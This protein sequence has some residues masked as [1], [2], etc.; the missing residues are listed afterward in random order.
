MNWFIISGVSNLLLYGL[1]QTVE[2]GMVGSP[3]LDAERTLAYLLGLHAHWLAQS[4][5]LQ[6]V[7]EEVRVGS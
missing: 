7:E 4:T 3:L 1:L 5:P 6:P 2:L